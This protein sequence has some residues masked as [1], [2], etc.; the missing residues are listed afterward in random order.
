MPT[1]T[2]DIALFALYTALIFGAGYKVESWHTQSK[3][4]AELQKQ[5]IVT[6]AADK[7]AFDIAS[8]FE[9]STQ[10]ARDSQSQLLE[11]WNEAPHTACMLSDISIGLLTAATAP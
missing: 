8:K 2:V 9:A 3:Q 5:V 11:K 7:K 4:G 6:N 1:V 10:S